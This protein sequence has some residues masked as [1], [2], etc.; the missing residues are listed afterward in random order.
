M[1]A[2]LNGL[3]KLWSAVKGRK[4]SILHPLTVE[5]LKGKKKTV[6]L[7]QGF[8]DIYPYD[9]PEPPRDSSSLSGVTTWGEEN[10][11]G[12]LRERPWVAP[13]LTAGDDAVARLP[14]LVGI[15][16]AVLQSLGGRPQRSPTR[17]MESPYPF[18]LVTIL[19]GSVS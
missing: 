3:K 17:P 1:P 19:E 4:A 6:G 14:V 10:D 11:E 9:T 7:A 18:G 12:E 2:T 13:A 16:P 8:N 5:K 15:D